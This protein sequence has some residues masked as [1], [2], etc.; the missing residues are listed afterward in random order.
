VPLS[1]GR[2]I[3]HDY[4]RLMHPVAKI[5]P[6][7]LPIDGVLN[8]AAWLSEETRIRGIKSVSVN[9]RECVEVSIE[10]PFKRYKRDAEGK[11]GITVEQHS[12]VGV[13]DPV[14]EWVLLSFE[15]IGAPGFKTTNEFSFDEDIGGFPFETSSKMEVRNMTADTIKL[16]TTFQR[17]RAAVLALLING[18]IGSTC[19]WC[20]SLQ[21]GSGVATPLKVHALHFAHCGRSRRRT[22]QC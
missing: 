2:D 12:A 21:M 5:L 9:N 4:N 14:K 19:C 15:W 20:G 8:K 10:F 17:S 3:V 16:S 7:T 1:D 6:Q 22:T 18:W 13:F 11:A